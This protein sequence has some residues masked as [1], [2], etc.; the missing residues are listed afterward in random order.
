MK[1]E[2]RSDAGYPTYTILL[3]TVSCFSRLFVFFNFMPSS[4]IQG[5][6]Y[7]RRDYFIIA[8][9][10]PGIRV[11][12]DFSTFGFLWDWSLFFIVIVDVAC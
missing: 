5:A 12:A 2:L 6:V 10:F 11:F 3:T 1:V 4:F 7:Q 8:E 9:V